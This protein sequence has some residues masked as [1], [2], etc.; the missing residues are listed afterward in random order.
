M[1]DYGT[2]LEVTERTVYH[3]ESGNLLPSSMV[4]TLYRQPFLA[5]VLTREIYMP[6]A[7]SATGSYMVIRGDTLEDLKRKSEDLNLTIW[8]PLPPPGSGLDWN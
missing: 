6:N 5:L 3:V 4:V 1:Q 8:K 7:T 2:V